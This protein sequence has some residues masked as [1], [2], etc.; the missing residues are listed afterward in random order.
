MH[1]HTHTNREERKAEQDR[2]RQR[3]TDRRREVLWLDTAQRTS[4]SSLPWGWIVA[5]LRQ[6]EYSCLGLERTQKEQ[7]K[8]RGPATSLVGTDGY[9]TRESGQDIP[10]H[11]LGYGYGDRSRKCHP[12]S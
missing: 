9:P 6:R 8:G 4:T 5:R 7:A 11:I 1:V 2:L 12:H 10:S 3:E